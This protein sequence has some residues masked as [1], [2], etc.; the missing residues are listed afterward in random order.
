VELDRVREKAKFRD[1]AN[2]SQSTPAASHKSNHIIN[3]RSPSSSIP[4]GVR[5]VRLPWVCGQATL[6]PQWLALRRT[7]TTGKL[8]PEAHR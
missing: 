3:G 4:A 7:P 6:T 8:G 1:L 5:A 2:Y